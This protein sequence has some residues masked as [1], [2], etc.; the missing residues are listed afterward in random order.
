MLT[1]CKYSSILSLEVNCF[2]NTYKKNIYIPFYV[3]T[4]R[5]LQIIFKIKDYIRYKHSPA[6]SEAPYEQSPVLVVKPLM[7]TV[8]PVV[9]PLM[10][11][12]LC[13]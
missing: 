8:L 13:L 9:K 12:V 3:Y 1:I 11:T 7:S 10:D 6:C 5:R 4:G 2:T